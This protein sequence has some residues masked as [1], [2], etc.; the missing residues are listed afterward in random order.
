MGYFAINDNNHIL[1]SGEACVITS[2]QS[3]MNKYIKSI[4]QGS[5]L[6]ENRKTRLEHVI[7]GLAK[8]A[9]YAFDKDAYI[10]FQALSKKSGLIITEK[11]TYI[12]TSGIFFTI[13]STT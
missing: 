13:V 9:K 5:L 12:D 6:Y 7:E 3:A 8:G 1:C 4:P 2:T 11:N 10:L